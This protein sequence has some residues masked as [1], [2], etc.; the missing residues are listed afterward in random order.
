MDCVDADIFLYLLAWL[1]EW[2]ELPL[3]SW[4][5]PKINGSFSATD[6]A[7]RLKYLLDFTI[8]HAPL[9]EG[10]FSWRLDLKF[11]RSESRRHLTAGNT[12]AGDKK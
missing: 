8:T 7:R 3:S 2:C 6:P 1:L 9:S 4:N 12:G 10:L 11:A 5:D